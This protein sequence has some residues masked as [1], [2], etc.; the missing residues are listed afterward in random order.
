MKKID[1]HIHTISTVNDH[2]FTFSINTLKKYVD[3]RELDC[4]AIT[5]HNMFDITQYQEISKELSITVL[6][7]IEIDLEKGHLLLISD[8]MELHDFNAKCSQVTEAIPTK[9]DS[10]TVLQLKQ[11]FPDLSKYILIPHYNKSP[12]IEEDTLLEL[13]PFITAG[14]VTSPKKF[15]YCLK[16]NDS[17]VP[18]LFGD[19]RIEEN[20]S[21]FP[22][23]QTYIDVGEITH[24]A[25]KNSLR[26]KNKV[27]LS[28]EDGHKFFDAL[29]NG[30]KLSTGLNV[31]LG[32]RS[33]G[34][35]FTLNRISHEFE[36]VKYIKQFSL[37]ERDEKS[38]AKRFNNLLTTKQSIFTRDYLKE[39]QG[40]VDSITDV[41]I[42]KD[43]RLL[44]KYI[45]SLV[46]HAKESEKADSYSKAYLFNE[47]DFPIDNPENL[48]SLIDSVVELIENTEYRELI[49]KH[50]SL[51]SFKKLAIDLIHKY[52]QEIST[53]LK[54]QYIN[55]LVTSIKSE[56]RVHTAATLIEDVDF[57]QISINRKKV[58]KF[59][60][61]VNAAKNDK[62]IFRK[63]I[64]GYVIVANRKRFL[65][66][67]KLKSI[68]G[69]KLTF[70]AAFDK[71]IDPYNYLKKLTEINGLEESEYHKYFINIE[72]KI[73]NKHGY[74]VSGRERSEFRL[75]QEINDA[76]Q[77]E[78]L[79]IDEPESSFDNFFLMNKV[80][81]LIKN[82]SKN[83]PVIIVTHNNTVGASIKP[84]Y[85][86]YTRKQVKD[87][88]VSYEIYS[89]H[90]S[91]KFLTGLNGKT[92]KNHEAL[93][94]C[95]EAG[96]TAYNERGESYEVLKN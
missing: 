10:I 20:L 26:D 19:L 94:N 23:R 56:L 73:L 86:I 2:D 38:D 61:V 48:K 4:I 90:P 58:E 68:S 52:T 7:G 60:N 8:G 66:A 9:E 41:D 87:E 25:I 77:H 57:Y 40:V 72:Y 84:D 81:E 78:M 70:S 34:K 79:L 24:S 76:Q 5:N 74:E 54:K 6:P 32:E 62:E 53:N 69:R 96:E 85:V 89:G 39:L 83:M 64:Q 29:E 17:L 1:L 88:N 3:S 12:C 47:S 33:T 71:Y 55:D 91:D 95:L 13:K 11:F 36:N 22:T 30:L 27:F 80:N 21:T 44:E 75:L 45:T 18:V 65:G 67:Q 15:Q 35:S 51:D 63:E 42:E 92:I 59:R 28:K 16:D 31:V 43:D 46:K 37:L 93:L 82:I 49:D 14:E 50:I